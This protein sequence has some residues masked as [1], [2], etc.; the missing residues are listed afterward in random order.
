MILLCA[1]SSP[2]F[3][4]ELERLVN[5]TL[6]PRPEK[7]SWGDDDDSSTDEP[8]PKPDPKV[9]AKITAD[10]KKRLN[11]ILSFYVE[12]SAGIRGANS[13]LTKGRPRVPG[14]VQVIS[15]QLP[16][17]EALLTPPAEGDVAP[18][19]D[20]GVAPAAQALLKLCTEYR[21]PE[22]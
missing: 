4:K 21:H 22:E 9:V 1:E 17:I 6:P 19:P 5:A 12:L 2:F 11:A 14:Y 15:D 3:Q 20:A 13:V 18:V 10:L 8:P 16:E 7:P